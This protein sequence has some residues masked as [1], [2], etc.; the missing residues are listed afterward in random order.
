MDN[1]DI[2]CTHRQS[3]AHGFAQIAKNST[4][5]LLNSFIQDNQIPFDWEK[6]EATTTRKGEVVYVSK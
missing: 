3:T 6:C 4:P 1:G 5:D 2:Y